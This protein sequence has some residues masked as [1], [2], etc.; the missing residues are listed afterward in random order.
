M[1]KSTLTGLIF[2]SAS[3]LAF[4][5][6]LTRLFSVAQFYHFAFMIVSLALLGYGASGTFLAIF[7]KIKD[8]NL[9]QTLGWISTGQA[10]TILGAYLFANGLP[11]NSFSIAWDT[12]QAVLLMGQF[13]ALALP[14]FFNGLGVGVLL[15]ASPSGAARIYAV[16]LAWIS[17]WLPPG[18]DRPIQIRRGGNDYTLQRV[19]GI[20]SSIVFHHPKRCKHDRERN[21]AFFT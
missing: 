19:S 17:C 11:F 1:S 7:P 10:I 9:A 5:I 13:L 6:N 12:K 15:A 14:F 21:K 8:K 3:A 18:V 4:E 20:I 2:L 16:K